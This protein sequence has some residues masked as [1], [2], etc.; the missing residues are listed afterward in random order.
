MNTLDAASDLVEQLTDALGVLVD[1][2]TLDG[3]TIKA[4][5]RAAVI[6]YPPRLKMPTWADDDT[7]VHWT[8]VAAASGD[9]LTAWERLDRII[10][11]L[12]H[13][14]LNL[15]DATP[16]TLSLAGAATLSAYEITLNPL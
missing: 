11:R 13:S 8:I 12:Q 9:T 10:D 1:Q 16:S 15:A 14:G 2:I 5:T 4:Q 3:S 7:E 6:I